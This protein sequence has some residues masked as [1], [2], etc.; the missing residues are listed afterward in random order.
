MARPDFAFQTSTHTI[1]QGE[2]KD[3]FVASPGQLVFHLSPERQ[4]LPP[5]LD[6]PEMERAVMAWLMARGG[7]RLNLNGRSREIAPHHLDRLPAGP[8]SRLIS[9]APSNAEIVGA[10]GATHL[11]VGVE[12]SSD[13]PPEVKRLPQLGPDLFVDLP[14]LTALQP[15]LVLASLT[16]PGMERNITALEQAG[17]PYLVLAP[18]TL[19]EI[20]ASMARVG[21]VLGMTEQADAALRDFQDRI[22]RFRQ[23]AGSAP[24]TRVYLEWWPKPMFTPGSVCWSNELI[25]LAGGVNVF[26]ALPGQ[27]QEVSAAQVAEADPQVVFVSWCGVPANKLDPERVL[28]REGLEAVS[29]VRNGRVFAVDEALMGRPGP[30]VL[31]GV[32][33]MAEYIRAWQIRSGNQ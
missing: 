15:D 25:R 28:K 6:T 24:P 10:L 3:R 31:D 33:R 1:H 26:S 29:A 14:A 11:L 12:S 13:F 32:A 22:E 2:G 30:R 21:E 4:E 5:E 17:I 7:R 9:I 23:E 20:G 18:T 19:A 16:V 8:V 27:S